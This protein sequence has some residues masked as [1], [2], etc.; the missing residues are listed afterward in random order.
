MINYQPPNGVCEDFTLYDILMENRETFNTFY[1]YGYKIHSL[2]AMG[3]FV[4]DKDDI[5]YRKI[6]EINKLKSKICDY[7]TYEGLGRLK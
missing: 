1:I 7:M 5:K 3:G 6:S 4:I 2:N